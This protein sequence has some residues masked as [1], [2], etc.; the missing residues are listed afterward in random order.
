MHVMFCDAMYHNPIYNFCWISIVIS[1]YL[2]I[3]PAWEQLLVDLMDQISMYIIQHVHLIAIIVDYGLGYGY[4]LDDF[5]EPTCG[6]DYMAVRCRYQ[7]ANSPST[8]VGNHDHRQL[9]VY[10]FFFYYIIIAEYTNNFY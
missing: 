1:V 5:L 10:L 7:S 4:H 2:L 9:C 8:H 6:L 3:L